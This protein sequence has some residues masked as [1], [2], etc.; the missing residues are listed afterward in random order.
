MAVNTESRG[1]GRRRFWRLAAWAAG[2]A[3]VLLPLLALSVMQ[4][5]ADEGRVVRRSVS[6]TEGPPFLSKP[7]GPAHDA[8][9]PGGPS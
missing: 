9:R 2:A 7:S 5:A 3:V 1:E 8:H 4:A 6:L